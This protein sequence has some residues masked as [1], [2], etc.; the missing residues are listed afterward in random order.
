MKK[1]PR[2][3]LLARHQGAEPKLDQVRREAL[4]RLERNEEAPVRSLILPVSWLAWLWQE[5]FLPARF[6]W[7]GLA[8]TWVVILALNW[9][10]GETATQTTD[11]KTVSPEAMAFFLEQRREWPELWDR[12]VATLPPV[13]P[14]SAPLRPRSEQ[15]SRQAM[16]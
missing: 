14:T 4:A 16:A 6:V 1:T 12:T 3:M 15:T 5:L 8:A 9:G 2:E 11:A 13:V 7:G 10:G